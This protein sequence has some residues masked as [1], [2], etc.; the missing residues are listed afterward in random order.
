MKDKLIAIGVVSAALFL[1]VVMN[2]LKP[3]A[4]KAPEPE[5]AMAV[6]TEVV[7]S[8]RLEMRV[9]S[10]G[11]VA[12]RTRTTL[13]SEVSGAVLDVSDAF[14][15][16]GTFKTGDMLLTLDPTD[17][18]VALQRAEAKL[19]SFKALMELEKARSVQAEKE[20]GMTGRP[21][22]EAPL[23]ALRKPYLL[24]AQANLLQAEAEVR[25]AKVKLAKTIIKAP[26]AGMVSKKLADI[27]QFVTTGTRI[28]ET[29]AIDFVE[30]RLPLTEK[31]LTMMEGLSSKATLAGTDVILSGTVDGMNSSWPAVIER[32]EGV[33]DQLNRSQYIVARVPDPYGVNRTAVKGQTASTES[34]DKKQAPLRV[35][36]FVK[37]SIQGKVLNDVFKIPRSALLEGSRVGL[38]DENSLLQIISVIV[39]STDDDHY[40]ISEGLVNGQE[41]IISALGTPIEGLKLR[42]RN[43]LSVGGAK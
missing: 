14:V 25:Q 27:G 28:G 15:V 6:K 2:L 34:T 40:Y 13:I 4:V 11:I 29:F 19:I 10:Q 21:K 38:V 35:G 16:G 12:P 1:A 18:Q 39:V 32:S 5:A 3:D 33:V 37:A 41:V 43:N 30:I 23:L 31:D 9:E 8:A 42:V 22:S 36:T 17:Y 24:E 26:Y 7:N 20:W